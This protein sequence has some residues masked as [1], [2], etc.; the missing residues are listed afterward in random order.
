MRRSMLRSTT[1]VSITKSSVPPAHRQ[2]CCCTDGGSSADNMAVIAGALADE[3][4]VFNVDLPGHGLSPAPREALGVKEHA[5][6]IRRFI[7]DK[8][9]EAVTVIGHSNGGRI[10]LFMASDPEMA[11]LIRR[12][13]LVSPSGVAPH[14]STG[15]YLKNYTVRALKLPFEVLPGRLREDGLDWLRHSLV[16]RAL[17]SSDYR[18]L[19]GVMRA[20]FVKTVNYHLDDRLPHVEVPTLLF[21][22]DRDT[23]VSKRQMEVLEDNIPDAGLVL[24]E[25][26]GH[27]G[28]LDDFET[29][30]SA[31]RYFLD[32]S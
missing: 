26:A 10:S 15:Y 12:L 11:H 29:F 21:W 14:R 16:W 13:V 32:N 20:T 18:A 31:T 8:I 30:I 4:H 28:Y 23:A 6:L 17:G 22:G 19:E 27:Y 2:Y 1:G 24:L 5:G 9:G 3:C 7:D 25:G